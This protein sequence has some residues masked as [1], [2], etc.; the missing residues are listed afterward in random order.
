VDW[1][2]YGRTV[3]A[4]RTRSTECALADRSNLNVSAGARSSKCKLSCVPID[5]RADSDIYIERSVQWHDADNMAV[6]IRNG[7]IIS[8]HAGRMTAVTTLSNEKPAAGNVSAPL[9]V[10][11]RTAGGWAS[12]T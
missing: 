2:I 11:V 12:T 3:H 9:T 4:D 10:C 5:V 7:S 6:G 8:R 1:N